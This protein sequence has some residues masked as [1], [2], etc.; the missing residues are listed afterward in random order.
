MNAVVASDLSKAYKLYHHPSD[1]LIEA[2]HPWRRKYHQDFFAL[3]ELN[4]LIK[5][6]ETFGIIGRN[7]SGK[8]TLLKLIAGILSPTTGSIAVQGKV[9]A[10]LELGAGFNPELTG[11]ENIYFS[12]TLMGFTRKEMD[13]RL[14]NVVSFADIGDF[15]DQPIK[16]YSSGMFIRLAFATAINVN[17]DV[18]II[19]EALAVGDMNFQARCFRKL[20]DFKKNGKTV[21]IVTH[22]LDSVIRYCS[23]V[24]VLDKGKMVIESEPKE[25]V[26]VYKRLMTHSYFPDSDFMEKKKKVVKH[27]AV[28]DRSNMQNSDALS[29]GN[30]LAEIVD[31]DIYDEN[32]QPVKLLYHNQLFF[33]GIKITFHRDIEN[34]IFAYTIKDLKGLELT[35]TNT[36]FKNVN[37]GCYRKDESIL[38][39]FSQRLNCQSGK[40]TLS[41]G[42]TGFENGEFIVYHRLYDALFFKVVSEMQMVGFYDLDSMIEIKKS[43]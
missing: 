23:K 19:D 32:H 40:Y 31:F 21:I 18:L 7:G 35:G 9:S 8:S 43:T 12:G 33:V 1:R 14:P 30:K 13:K 27:V 11:I 34:P 6:G 10:L 4:F 24:L 38:V 36:L 2:V 5:Q 26:D 25:A 17:P 39:E 16:T 41:F 20:D 22:A 42:C 3:A 15:I 28:P 37:S 29:Y